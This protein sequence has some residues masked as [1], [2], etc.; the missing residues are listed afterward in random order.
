MHKCSVLF[1]WFFSTLPSLNFP[2]VGIDLLLTHVLERVGCVVGAVD[3]SIV[4]V[5]TLNDALGSL[6]SPLVTALLHTQSTSTCVTAVKCRHTHTHMHL[7]FQ[8]YF[9]KAGYGSANLTQKVFC[10]FFFLLHIRLFDTY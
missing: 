1:T 2:F 8:C 3:H 5:V 7:M 4:L 9:I 6:L 10:H